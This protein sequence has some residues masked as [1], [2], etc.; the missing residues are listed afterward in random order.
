MIYLNISVDEFFTKHPELKDQCIN[1][2]KEMNIPLNQIRP[3]VTKETIG[4]EFDEDGLRSIDILRDE[5]IF[6]Q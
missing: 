1:I 2:C 4:V 5:S 3:Y 6:Y